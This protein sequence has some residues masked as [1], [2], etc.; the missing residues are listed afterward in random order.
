[1]KDNIKAVQKKALTEKSFNVTRKIPHQLYNFI[2]N[3]TSQQHQ[4]VQ[5]MYIKMQ[6]PPQHFTT[7]YMKIHLKSDCFKTN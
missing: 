4:S 1:M 2:T 6:N 3:C 7:A 5:H